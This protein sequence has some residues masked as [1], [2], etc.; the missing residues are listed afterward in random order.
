MA[1]I[2]HHHIAPRLMK[3][4]SHTATPFL[5]FRGLLQGDLYLYLYQYL[6][7][8]LYLVSRRLFGPQSQSGHDDEAGK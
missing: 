3:E 1:L 4:Y 7:V 6:P 5:G 8:Y 2:T